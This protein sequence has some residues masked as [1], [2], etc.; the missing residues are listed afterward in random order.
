MLSDHHL[1]CRKRKK[2][3]YYV[4]E[5]RA[6]QLQWAV[7]GLTGTSFDY[8]FLIIADILSKDSHELYKPE[9]PPLP[10]SLYVAYLVLRSGT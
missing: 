7:L 6:K 10:S 1:I 4:Y 5:N 2:C 3:W 8:K 9:S